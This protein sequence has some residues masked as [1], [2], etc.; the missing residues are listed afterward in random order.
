MRSACA[1]PDLIAKKRE[2]RAFAI[3]PGS[4]DAEGGL[5]SASQANR[6][7]RRA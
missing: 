7:R 2:K 3:V 1:P 6:L 5:L 4:K